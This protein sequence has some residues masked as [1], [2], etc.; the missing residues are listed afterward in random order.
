MIFDLPQPAIIQRAEPWELELHRKLSLL[1]LPRHV[2]RAIVA[3]FKRLEG[4][5]RSIVKPALDDLARYGKEPAL[6]HILCPPIGWKA[7]TAGA[8]TSIAYVTHTTSTGGTITAPA[9]GIEPGDLLVLIQYSQ[10]IPSAGPGT[11]VTPDGFTDMPPSPSING[12]GGTNRSGRMSGKYKIADGSED[13]ATITGMNDSLDDKIL[14]QYRAD[15][16]L[17]SLSVATAVIDATTGNPAQQTLLAGSGTP[18]VLGIT[19]FGATGTVSPRTTSITPDHEMTSSSHLYAHD[20]VQNSSP[21]N[22]T[23]DMDDEGTANVLYGV[24]LHSFVAA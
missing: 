11:D 23:W 20:F 3:E 22:Y 14:I 15:A 10:S 16:P 8:V 21:S 5:S 12:G 1:G 24:Y 4:S 18:P 2:R 17:A 19:A 6:A 9:S 7:A 13:G